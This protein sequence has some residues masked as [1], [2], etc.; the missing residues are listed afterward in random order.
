MLGDGRWMGLG[1][2]IGGLARVEIPVGKGCGGAPPG[3]HHPQD[4][5]SIKTPGFQRSWQSAGLG[6][7]SSGF[8][9]D[10]FH[11]PCYMPFSCRWRFEMK[12]R[13][14]PD[15]PG[16]SSSGSSW[17][18][19]RHSLLPSLQVILSSFMPSSLPT[20]GPSPLVRSAG[21]RYW[22]AGA[23]EKR[24]LPIFLATHHKP[25]NTPFFSRCFQFLCLP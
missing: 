20:P 16:Q 7:Q 11:K 5:P 3:Q 18:M 9:P 8:E 4:F 15:L 1:I 6:I 14:F 2:G 10:L 12:L 17:S 19:I 25:P 22:W 21:W 13:T 24:L 23:V